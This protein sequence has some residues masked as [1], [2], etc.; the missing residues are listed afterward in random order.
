LFRAFLKGKFMSVFHCRYVGHISSTNKWHGIK[1]INVRGRHIPQVYETKEYRQFKNSLILK[2]KGIIRLDS[3]KYFDIKIK[4]SLR[5]GRDTSNCL[6][7]T[8]DAIQEAGIIKNDNKI[9]NI[10][11]QRAY[12]KKGE[13][14]VLEIDLYNI[15]P[16]SDEWA[17]VQHGELF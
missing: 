12:H 17:E 10:F 6:K 5:K 14:D 3:D 1:V 11:I 8:E 15:K 7:P 13:P 9:R 4:V 16:Q 2:I